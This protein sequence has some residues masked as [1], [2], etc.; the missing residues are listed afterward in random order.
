MAWLLALL[1]ATAHAQNVKPE[2]AQQLKEDVEKFVK[3]AVRQQC[4][5]R[6]PG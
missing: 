2:P 5:A 3:C 6:P 1:V 4:E